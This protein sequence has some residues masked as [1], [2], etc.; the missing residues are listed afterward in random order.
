MVNL[1][2]PHPYH[3]RYSIG[4]I[5]AGTSLFGML[6]IILGIYYVNS[7]VLLSTDKDTYSLTA[8]IMMSFVL[9]IGL[10]ALNQKAVMEGISMILIGISAVSF[11][12][13]YILG[14]NDE[15]HVLDFLLGIGLLVIALAFYTRKD[16]PLALGTFAAA[17][18]LIL[19][20]LF[21]EGSLIFVGMALGISG[22][23]YLV[24]GF[25]AWYSVCIDKETYAWQKDGKASAADNAIGTAGFMMMGILSIL[26]GL[27]YINFNLEI[28]TMDPITYNVA[29]ILMSA[30][31]LYY[32]AVAIRDG[33][34]TSGM[35]SLFFGSST[36]TFSACA[37]AGLGGLEVADVMFGIGM[38]M[39]CIVAYK[40]KNISASVIGLLVFIGF[41]IYPFF[42]G[43]VIYW[44]VGVPILIVGIIMA[45]NSVRNIFALEIKPY[46][47]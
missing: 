7:N 4:A 37:L 29:K 27:Y 6:M 18:G 36:F 21:G 20:P 19:Y 34:I 39:A 9:C 17:L 13:A 42:D 47:T 30:V 41:S 12:A 44:M 24:Y 35:M 23:M 14:G 5:I 22:L 8:V 31:I 43:N 32:A 26:V 2:V 1:F 33:S 40:E 28:F 10:Y 45:Y 38:L 3:N 46:K 25:H 11:S 16:W 15:L